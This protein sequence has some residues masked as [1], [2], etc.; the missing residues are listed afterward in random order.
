MCDGI[1]R[2]ASNRQPTQG[3]NEYAWS[4]LDGAKDEGTRF[5]AVLEIP[6]VVDA[7]TAVRVQI[8]SDSKKSKKRNK[9]GIFLMLTLISLVVV[10][11]TIL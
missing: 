7:T 3:G 2:G 8:V 10:W 1:F 4:H 9:N 5:V 11:I 6:P